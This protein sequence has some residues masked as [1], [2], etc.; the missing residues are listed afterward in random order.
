MNNTK[1]WW[2]GL[3]C[4]NPICKLK[5]R[6]ALASAIS[7]F[8]HQDET[9]KSLY[10]RLMLLNKI[11]RCLLV[12]AFLW[13]GAVTSLQAADI[14]LVA[15]ASSVQFALRDIAKTFHQDTGKSVRFSFAS[16]GNLS[17]QIQQGAPFEL[18]LSA[19]RIYITRLQQQNRLQQRPVLY[20][21]G[22]LVLLVPDNKP[23]PT[24]LDQYWQQLQQAIDNGQLQRFAIA[25]P[26]HAPYGF[27]AR[28]VL[29]QQQL[30]TALQAHL[31]LA[32][33]AAQ[34]AQFIQS[35]AAQAGLTAYALAQTPALKRNTRSLLIPQA[36]HHPLEQVM[37]LL[38]RAG[39]TA[40]QF[41][42][43]LQQ[44]KAR[45]ILRHYGYTTP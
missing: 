10:N 23:A 15:A 6:R 42:Q 20:A 45:R 24:N 7:R 39:T 1:A 38:N 3:R 25:N 31:V 8:V 21:A 27:A 18:F 26:E 9:R 40:K 34:A 2:V 37:A 32:E 5:E 12:I 41:Y 28:E 36:L 30:W 22:R 14:P 35:G 43:Y 19:N 33:N 17:R 11:T 16:S 44:D 4:A 29:Q 13:L